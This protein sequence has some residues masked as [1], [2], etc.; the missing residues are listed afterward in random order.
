VV[1]SPSYPGAIDAFRA[2]GARLLTVPV[3]DDGAQIDSLR[4]LLT[5]AQVRL[6]YVTPSYNNPTGSLLSHTRRRELARIA[7]EFQ[8]PVIEDLVATESVLVPGAE[9]PPVGS[10]SGDG[11]VTTIGSMSKLFW[12]GLRVGWVRASEQ[13]VYRLAQLK[14]LADLSSSLLPQFVSVEL[15]RRLA[16]VRAWR[17]AD[18]QQRLQALRGWLAEYIPDWTWQ[19]PVGGNDLW[20]HLPR[21]SATEFL[22]IASRFGVSAAAGP[23]FS[24]DGGHADYVRLT[25]LL[26]EADLKEGVRR[27]AQAWRAYVPR[28][29][30]PLA[31][32]RTVV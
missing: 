3:D 13:T 22:Q 1:E 9:L 27:L 6:I 28:S 20:I 31:D 24:A 14:A 5:R 8:V 12:G 23:L 11:W 30:A 18:C 25:F 17:R 10:L 21:G 4:E 26:D 29:T 16:E 2:A 15:F 19:E 7:G 32:V